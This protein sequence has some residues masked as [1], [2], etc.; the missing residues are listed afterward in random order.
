VVAY[1][2]VAAQPAEPKVD[3]GPLGRLSHPVARVSRWSRERNFLLF[4]AT[5]QPSR[6]TT[7]LDIGVDDEVASSWPTANWFER[8]YPWPDAVT[9]AGLGEG[10]GFRAA[11]PTIRYVKVGGSSLPFA[12]GEFDVAYSNAVLEHVGDRDAQVAFVS[13]MCRVARVVFIT[14]PNRLFPVEV[15]TRLPLVHWLPWP[16]ASRVLANVR[17]GHGAGL[18]LLTPRQVL[19][20]F[21]RGTERRVVRRGMT[22]VAVAT[23]AAAARLR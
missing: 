22:I 21:P 12:D 4:M 17:P 20:L 6:E 19:R 1:P 18:S 15:H 23:A 7:V 8:R 11:H 3:A 2:D 16:I 10:R 13:E 9:A 14:T 5:V